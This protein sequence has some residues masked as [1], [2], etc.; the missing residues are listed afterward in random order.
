MTRMIISLFAAALFTLGT[1]APAVACGG[2]GNTSAEKSKKG[3]KKPRAE[4]SK[5]TKAPKS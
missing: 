5:D 1:V 3:D 2:S 4:K